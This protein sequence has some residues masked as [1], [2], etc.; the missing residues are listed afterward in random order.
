MYMPSEFALIGSAVVA[1]AP[2]SSGR[3]WMLWAEKYVASLSGKDFL[4]TVG[5]VLQYMALVL[6]ITFIH[7]YVL[8]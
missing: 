5:R 7:R 2:K 6:M 8:D 4:D 3:L 1:L